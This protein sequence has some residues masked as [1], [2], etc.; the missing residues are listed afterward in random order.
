MAAADYTD[1]CPVCGPGDPPA[2]PPAGFPRRVPGGL[3]TAHQCAVCSTAW[4]TFWRE[5]WPIDRLIAPVGPEQAAR[6]R[7]ALEG[8]L[9]QTGSAA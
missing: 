4:E 8:A 2:S 7:A 3:L 9:R 5:G 6:N 1:A